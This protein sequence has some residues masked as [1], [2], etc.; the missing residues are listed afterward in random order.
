MVMVK[1]DSQEQTRINRNGADLAAAAVR[2]R[3]RIIS[4]TTEEV[5]RLFGVSPATVYAWAGR[6]LLTPCSATPSGKEKFLREDISGLLEFLG[7]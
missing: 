7:V 1:A 5:S 6:G 4:L 2:S 3:G